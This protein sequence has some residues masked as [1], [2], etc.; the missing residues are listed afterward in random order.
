MGHRRRGR[1]P[2]RTSGHFLSSA[3]DVTHRLSQATNERARPPAKT[4]AQHRAA[5]LSVA[6]VL[7]AGNALVIIH[8]L[9]CQAVAWP[10]GVG[11]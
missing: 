9:D 11:E 1:Q 10:R 2:V 4:H 3:E 6:A 8:E 7:L 5:A